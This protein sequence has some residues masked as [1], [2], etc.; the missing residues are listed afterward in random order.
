MHANIKFIIFILFL[1]TLIVM[2]SLAACEGTSDE[3]L[4]TIVRQLVPAGIDVVLLLEEQVRMI[5]SGA[6]KVL[7]DYSRNRL[8]VH[9]PSNE[10]LE[11][12]VDVPIELDVVFATENRYSS[13]NSLFKTRQYVSSV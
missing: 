13:F 1:P 5:V 9:L 2:L 10:L 4:L 7:Y 6:T 3:N 12:E 11:L 8:R